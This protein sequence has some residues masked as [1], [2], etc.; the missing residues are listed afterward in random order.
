M[1]S[2]HSGQLTLASEL[3]KLPRLRLELRNLGLNLNAI[4]HLM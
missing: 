2:V 4:R 3:D 1:G